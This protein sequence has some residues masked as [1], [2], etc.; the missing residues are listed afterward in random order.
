MI[1]LFLFISLVLAVDVFAATER[2]YLK[3]KSLVTTDEVRLSDISNWKKD[4]NP[5]VYKK[6]EE[7]KIVRPEEL[8]SYLDQILQS[9]KIENFEIEVLGRDAMI[10]PLTESVTGDFLVN[11]LKN[12]LGT[13]QN[14]I[15]SNYKFYAEKE[16]L[17]VVRGADF[18]F[19]K[20]GKN[21][22]GGKRILPLDFYHSGK[23]V[24]SESVSFLI[25]EKR[26]A[27]FT[28]KEV[29]AKQVISEDDVELREFYTM[30]HNREF[31]EE[32]PVGKTSLNLLAYDTAIEKKQ[33]RLL[34]TVE[35]GSEVQLVY[36]TG[37][38]LLKLKTRAL[39]SGNVGEEIPLL[40]LYS[41]KIVKARVQKEG[42]CLLGENG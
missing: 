7:P 5:V 1:R 2:I 39:A 22:H 17:P 23:L 20:T 32:N 34:H 13:E 33:I 25:E 40:N 30:D 37:N 11:S 8:K 31:V 28:T 42:V 6:L 36:T 12:E 38:I 10:I 9:S 29:P 3:P 14:M 15:L 35:R 24:H 26:K 18:K 4:W 19:R 16:K 41:Q 27:Y 21:L